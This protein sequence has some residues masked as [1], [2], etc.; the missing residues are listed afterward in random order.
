VCI[1]NDKL[2]IYTDI[3]WI[4]NDNNDYYLKVSLSKRK[5]SPEDYG[6][7]KDYLL[8][9]IPTDITMKWNEMEG[10]YIWEPASIEELHKYI[11]DLTLRRNSQC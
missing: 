7:L 1:Q 11:K 8:S 4:R 6:L 2:Q 3:R 9:Y 10:V 5:V